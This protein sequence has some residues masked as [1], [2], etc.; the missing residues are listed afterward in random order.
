[1]KGNETGHCTTL[2]AQTRKLYLYLSHWNKV[3][4]TFKARVEGEKYVKSMHIKL[5]NINNHP[6]YQN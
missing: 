2:L 6:L 5:K 3:N 1:M 4:F